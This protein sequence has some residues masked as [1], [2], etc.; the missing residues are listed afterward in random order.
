MQSDPEASKCA[1]ERQQR[2]LANI[3]PIDV[4]RNIAGLKPETTL[5]VVVSKTFT[6]TK[7][8]L[9]AQ[10]LRAWIS[11][12]LGL[13]KSLASILLMLSHSGTRLV[14]DLVFAVLVCCLCL[15]TMVSQLLGSMVTSDRFNSQSGKSSQS[16]A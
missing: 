3:D 15:S 14:A 4:A 1:V 9:N 12:E 6:K 2:F 5:V 7:T 13:G 16:L 11:K 8:M 10:T